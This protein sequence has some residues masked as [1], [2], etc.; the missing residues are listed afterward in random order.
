[1]EGGRKQLSNFERQVI[2]LSKNEN[3]TW[4][5]TKYLAALL[6]FFLTITRN[7]FNNVVATL[8]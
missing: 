5:L 3:P 7:Q 6:N 4:G 2:V 1:M 8:T